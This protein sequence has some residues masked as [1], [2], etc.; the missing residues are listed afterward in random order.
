MVDGSGTGSYATGHLHQYTEVADVVV[1]TKMD[2]A[3]HLEWNLGQSRENV[4]RAWLRAFVL[5]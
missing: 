2:L 3:A 5:G 1:L 4:C